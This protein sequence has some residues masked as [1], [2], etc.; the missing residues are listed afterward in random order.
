MALSK[1]FGGLFGGSSGDEVPDQKVVGEPVIYEGY[2]IEAMPR[3]DGSQWQLYGR[4]SKGEGDSQQVHE[5]IRADYFSGLEEAVSF[6]LRK[7]QQVID[8]QGD[9]IFRK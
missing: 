5:L 4:I 2:K 9:K 8:E 3:K 1:I 7:A 6:T